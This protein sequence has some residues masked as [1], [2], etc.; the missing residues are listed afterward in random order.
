MAQGPQAVGGCDAGGLVRKRR[1]L[2][3]EK[4]MKG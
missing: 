3:G 2:L 4:E 1:Q